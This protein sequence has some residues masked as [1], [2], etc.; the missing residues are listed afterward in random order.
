MSAISPR[1][2][3]TPD[4]RS[5]MVG[6]AAFACVA[7]PAAE[8]EDA[9][10]RAPALDLPKPGERD[11]CPVCGMFVA[12][13]PYWV[14]TLVWRD[15]AVIHFDGA[16]DLFKYLGDLAR[17]APGRRREEIAKVGVTA[18]YDGTRVDAFAASYVLGSDVYGPMG[19]EAV[20]HASRADAEEFLKD[21][22]GRRV[23]GAA[24]LTSALMRALDEGR[25]E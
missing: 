4:R 9:A 18:Y 5:V 14:A 8:A 7:V 1:R 16:K 24:D 3:A 19:H 6:L 2:L 11:L 12:K 20:P 23:V 15:G 17:W 21:H 22:K 10:G 13:Y 25:F